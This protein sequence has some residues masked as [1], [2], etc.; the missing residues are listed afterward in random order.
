MEIVACCLTLD[1]NAKC[2]IFTQ[3]MGVISSS[4]IFEEERRRK[5]INDKLKVDIHQKDFVQDMRN[6]LHEQR[7]IISKD[8]IINYHERQE[9][10]P[11]K[12]YSPFTKNPSVVILVDNNEIN[13][14]N[15]LDVFLQL[16][17][18]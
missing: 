15:I 3:R 1:S 2:R 14:Q 5:S 9:E 11:K 8:A 7:H 16:C 13:I 12:E 4:L 17:R 6:I 18:K 10:E